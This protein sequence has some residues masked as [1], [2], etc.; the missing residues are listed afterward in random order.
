MG[1]EKATGDGKGKEKGKGKR[2]GKVK[3]IVK[4]TSG[5]D[6]SYCA[7]ALQLQKEMNN[8]DSDTEA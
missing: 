7:V 6:D 5:G 8:A 4:R 1:I 2:N 3:G